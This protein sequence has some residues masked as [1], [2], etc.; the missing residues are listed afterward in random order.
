[1]QALDVHSSI[2][3]LCIEANHWT[4]TAVI[5]TWTLD[6][7]TPAAEGGGGGTLTVTNLSGASTTLTAADMEGQAYVLPSSLSGVHTITLPAAA[8]GLNATFILDDTNSTLKIVSLTGDSIHISAL[9]AGSAGYVASTAQG[10]SVTIVG[11]STS[12]FYTTSIVGTWA[13]NDETP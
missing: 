13:A 8:A 7:D 12:A 9:D 11:V 2:T 4:T 6:G 3:V 5:G 10:S 1:L